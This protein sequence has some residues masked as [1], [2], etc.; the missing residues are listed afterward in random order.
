MLIQAEN[1]SVLFILLSTSHLREIVFKYLLLYSSDDYI[2]REVTPLI[3]L[4]AIF[5][6]T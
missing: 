2:R 5:L 6:E 4:L 3:R 1:V